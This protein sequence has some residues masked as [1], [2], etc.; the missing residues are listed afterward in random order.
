MLKPLSIVLIASLCLALGACA[1]LTKEEI[2][3]RAELNCAAIDVALSTPVS[4]LLERVELGDSQ[5]QFALSLVLANG[6]SGLPVRPQMAA[7]WRS[8]A[9]AIKGTRTTSIYVPGYKHTPGSV[10]FVSSPS[11]DVPLPQQIDVDTCVAALN[12]PTSPA[13]LARVER[14][15]CGGPANFERLRTAWRQSQLQTH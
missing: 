3:A 7:L 4:L 11:Y 9:T 6:L 5:A 8:K 10:M 1:T 2:A 12:Q 13:S 15:A 14:G